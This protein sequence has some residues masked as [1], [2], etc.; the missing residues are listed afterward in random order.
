MEVVCFLG[1]DMDD[2]DDLAY[3]GGDVDSGRAGDA[4]DEMKPTETR[5]D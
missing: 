5:V 1:G 4:D 2:D 3:R